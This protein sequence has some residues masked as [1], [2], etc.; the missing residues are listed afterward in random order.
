[1]QLHNCTGVAVKVSDYD[2]AL[3]SFTCF[4]ME[5]HQPQ[6]TSNI[7]QSLSLMYPHKLVAG[8]NV[9]SHFRSLIREKVEYT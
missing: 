7:S 4:V 9:K 2:L 8:S 5:A 1:M 3:P 6:V